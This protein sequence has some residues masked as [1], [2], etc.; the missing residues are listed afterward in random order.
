MKILIVLAFC[1]AVISAGTPYLSAFTHAVRVPSW[2]SA[3]IRSDRLG[4]NFA[5]ST[6]EGHAYVAVAPILQ[7]TATPT[8][9]MA[10]PMI[11]NNDPTSAYALESATLPKEHR[12]LPLS[13]RATPFIANRHVAFIVQFIA[14]QTEMDSL[15]CNALFNKSFSTKR[16][17]GMIKWKPKLC[18]VCVRKK[19][20]L[21]CKPILKCTLLS[22]DKIPCYVEM[23]SLD[24]IR[25][26]GKREVSLLR[27]YSSVKRLFSPGWSST[28]KTNQS[29]AL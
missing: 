2:D 18:A 9:A 23:T 19:I 12:G 1:V 24:P 4:G 17:V 6:I 3:V 5:Y 28:K 15:L 11:S 29:S 22:S 10:A 27:E 8:D 16:N 25:F 13:F 26:F 7:H 21:A 14:M 20:A